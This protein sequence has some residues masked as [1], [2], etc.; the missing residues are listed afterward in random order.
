[1][2]ISLSKTY[3]QSHLLEDASFPDHPLTLDDLAEAAV[4]QQL[5]FYFRTPTLS[6]LQRRYF[7]IINCA[8]CADDLL[9]CPIEEGEFFEI[10]YGQNSKLSDDQ[11]ARV[12]VWLTDL[13][14]EKAVENVLRLLSGQAERI[15]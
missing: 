13:I 12:S 1:M 4:M 10:R 3:V 2:V 11:V 15:P 14:H 6:N 5:E 9:G 8:H 7:Q